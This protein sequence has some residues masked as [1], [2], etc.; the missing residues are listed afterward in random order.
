MRKHK[1]NICC[2]NRRDFFFYYE[3]QCKGFQPLPSLILTHF[4]TFRHHLG[5]TR[6]NN[7]YIDNFLENRK[8]G[9]EFKLSSTKENIL[10]AEHRKWPDVC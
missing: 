3:K 5:L 7:L 9:F 2:Y 1:N 10:P 4:P 8:L 6:K